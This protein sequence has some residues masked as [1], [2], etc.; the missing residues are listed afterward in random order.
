MNAKTN[1]KKDTD[2]KELN[3]FQQIVHRAEADKLSPKATGKIQYEV[4][5]H[6]QEKQLYIHLA[7]QTDSGLFSKEWIPIDSVLT[8]IEAQEVRT[9]NRC[10]SAPC[11]RSHFHWFEVRDLTCNLHHCGQ[12]VHLSAFH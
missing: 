12:S 7:G 9:L 11:L 6:Q 3:P 4:A 2:T 1:A 5:L 8:L 10:R